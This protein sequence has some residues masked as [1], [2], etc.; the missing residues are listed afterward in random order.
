[1][2]GKGA[3]TSHFIGSTELGTSPIRLFYQIRG[4]RIEFE[5][6]MKEAHLRLKMDIGRWIV[7]DRPQNFL[8]APVIYGLAVPLVLF[9]L[10]VTLFQAMCLPIYKIAKV[11][12]ADYIVLD[13]H[14]LGYLNAVER[15]HCTY[16][17]YVNGLFAYPC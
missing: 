1:M 17:E 9:D 12:R 11:R 4:K 6:S 14:N 7:S 10:C 15:F 16:C 5:H 3:A 13:R 2:Q 8:T